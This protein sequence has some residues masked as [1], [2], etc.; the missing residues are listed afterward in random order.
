[1]PGLN[2]IGDMDSSAQHGGMNESQLL[3]LHQSL[4]TSGA[5]RAALSEIDGTLYLG[6]PQL[7][8]DM[9]GTPAYM[10]GGNSDIDALIYRWTEG[11]FEEVERLR[12]PGGEDMAFFSIAAERYLATASIRTG[13]GPYD[14]NAVSTVFR[15]QQGS[16]APHQGIDTFAA[17]QCY[18]FSFS[19]R[20][21]LGLAQGVTLPGVE[22]RHPRESRI[23]EWDGAAF[24]D[25]QVLQGR[26][27]YGFSYFE[28]DGVHYL[29]YAD[30]TSPSLL[31]RWDGRAFS[32]L[33]SFS[34]QGGRAFRVFA[35]DNSWWLAFANISGESTLYRWDE[36]QFVPCQSLGGPGGR[37]FELFEAAGELYLVR[38]CF[39][40]GTPAA[41]K[42]DLLSQ[43]YHW[44]AGAFRV[45]DEFPTFGGT[46]AAVF[47]RDAQRFLVVT[48]SL[49][50]GVRFRQDTLVYRV[51]V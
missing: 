26:W 8:E 39:I 11:R 7:A 50:A 34:A 33:Q 21:F 44:H 2:E 43:I 6:V 45:I 35:A 22:A 20:S 19:G 41:P 29:A 14:L 13:S 28:I 25:F 5:R 51:H 49:T 4:P 37:A 10:N 36:G 27:G 17:K 30:H 3:Q 9:A 31:Y 1:M 15:L 24:R 16:W 12:V 40:E 46:D 23:L 32:R 48:N 38:V 18:A 47:T 42:T